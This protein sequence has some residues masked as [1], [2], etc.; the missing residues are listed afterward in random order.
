LAITLFST[1]EGLSPTFNQFG[2][3]PDDSTLL[4][5]TVRCSWRARRDPAGCQGGFPVFPMTRAPPRCRPGTARGSGA[6]GSAVL[7]KPIP[8]PISDFWDLGLSRSGRGGDF[9]FG[10]PEPVGGRGGPRPR[11][12]L[13]PGAEAPLMLGGEQSRS[14]AARSWPPQGGGPPPP[15]GG[16]GGP[17]PAKNPRGIWCWCNSMPHADLRHS[18]LGF[19]P[20]HA[21]PMPAC[22]ECSPVA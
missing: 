4:N 12:G 3:R 2:T 7:G 1:Q 20:Q 9:P 5:R 13:A 22:L 19:K 8:Q 10:A 15:G 21:A 16:P 6:G 14:A 18:W 17:P 11:G